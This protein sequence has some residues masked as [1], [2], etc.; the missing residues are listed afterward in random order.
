MKSPEPT[1]EHPPTDA[2]AGAVRGDA[3]G[4]AGGDDARRFGEAWARV[5]PAVYAWASLHV[6]PPLRVRLDPEDI[7]Q[8]V[9]FRAWTRFDTWD[10]ERGSFRNWVFGIA[11][12]VL[13]ETLRRMAVEALSRGGDLLTT[14]RM[15]ALPDT[16]TAVTRGV[17]R[18]E[19]LL[20]LVGEVQSLPDEDRRLL[21]LRGLE[22]LSHAE[23][24]TVLQM[25][26]DAV[27]KRW[28]R[29][30]ERLRSRPRWAELVVA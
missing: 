23:V 11:R 19:G 13:H 25:T 20:R 3:G 8:E 5:T 22:G 26:P 27:A 30:C 2:L 24:A 6:R 14:H 29:L 10:A 12:H 9:A 28:Q 1:P 15:E 7:L 17:A 18:D 4:D 16:A 21:L